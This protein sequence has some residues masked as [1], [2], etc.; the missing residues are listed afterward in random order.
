MPASA[1]SG[2]TLIELMIA[3]A[4]SS[5]ILMTAF[6]AL[7]VVSQSVTLTNRLSLENG[8]MRAG[9]MAASNE[10]D[11]WTAYDDPLDPTQQPLRA[12]GKPFAPLSYDPT[13]PISDPKHWWRGF[14]CTVSGVVSSTAWGDYSLMSQDGMADP[15]RSWLPGQTRNLLQTLGNYGTIGYL[16]GDAIFAY[17]NSSKNLTAVPKD[18]WAYTEGTAYTVDP[19]KP[20][21]QGAV[22]NLMPSRPASWPGLTIE[23]RR[24]VIYSHSLD[25][26][27]VKVTSPVTGETIRYA[28]WGVGTTLRGARQQ[29]GLDTV[30]IR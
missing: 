19:A 14:G 4:L 24:Y 10:L 1:R 18:V 27:L 22:G 25:T 12:V 21:N 13:K 29:R 5:V 11:F 17:Y 23:T 2:F 28:F 8:L 15:V 9:F 26:C 6:S 30:A 3:I 7:R 20:Y 16:P